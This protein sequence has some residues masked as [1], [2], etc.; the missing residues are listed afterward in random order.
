METIS[1]PPHNH[2]SSGPTVLPFT[3]TFMPIMYMIPPVEE[4]EEIQG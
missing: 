2:V 3:V 1:M 4:M